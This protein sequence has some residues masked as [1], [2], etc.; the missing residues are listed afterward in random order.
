MA[1]EPLSFYRR[2]LAWP[3]RTRGASGVGFAALLVVAQAANFA[4]FACQAVRE[5]FGRPTARRAS[6]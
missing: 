5:R 1:V 3:L 2:L 4:G 6:Q